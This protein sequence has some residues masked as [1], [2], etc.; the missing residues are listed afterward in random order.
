MVTHY[1]PY[2]DEFKVTPACGQWETENTEVNPSWKWVDCKKCLQQK[3]EIVKA[4]ERTER[5]IVRQMG[6]FVQ[7][8]KN[9]PF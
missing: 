1:D 9:N 3:D 6:D 5:E 2:P 4:V 8:N 7:F